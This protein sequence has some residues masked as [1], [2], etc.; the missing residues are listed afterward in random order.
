MIDLILF[1]AVIHTLD[2][3]MPRATAVAIWRERIV[4]VGTDSDIRALAGRN[5][6][7][8]NMDGLVILPGTIDSHV[9]FYGATDMLH[10]AN[11]YAS[12]SRR[13]A[14]ERVARFAAEHAAPDRDGWVVGYGWTQD[15]WADGGF[16]SAAD[17]DSMVM[18]R[19]VYLRSRSGH[20]AWVNSMALRLAGID[21][22]T[23]N[24]PGGEI[25][26]DATGEATGLLFEWPAMDL[27]GDRV[28]PLTPEALATRMKASQAW[29]HSQGVTGFH[30]LDNPDCLIGLQVLRERGELGLRVTKYVNREFLDAALTTGIR[31]GFGDDWLRIGGLK[32]FADGAIGT[33]TAAMFQPYE[34]EPDNLGLIVVSKEEMMELIPRASRAGLPST[35]H[36]IGDRAVRDVLDAFA[37]ARADE[38]ARGVPPEARRH[39]VEHVQLIDPADVN[40]LAELR[41]IASMQP[42]HATSDYPVADRYWG[43]RTAYSYNPR[44]Q[45][46]RGVVL[47]FGSDA[48]YDHLGAMRGIHAAVTRQRPDG[49]PPGGW[50]PEARITVDQAIRAY[51]IGAAYS[52]GME[53]RLGRIVPGYL[54]DL[55]MLDR[56]PYTE[57]PEQIH[58]IGV[59]GTMV[60]GVWRWQK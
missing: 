32:M 19:P 36:A 5:T 28:P 40:R 49:T 31:V 8:Q 26:R 25:V 7:E 52:V 55:T 37:F 56:D 47:A 17:L 54:A 57:P 51:T 38:A 18:D 39:R 44:L 6:I 50:H 35:I 33:R 45:A 11:L 27:V 20:A 59:R 29:L 3:A 46:D 14:A 48:P 53:D 16:P 43:A 9:H 15:D 58:A 12:A 23:P 13:E 21:K 42:I 30:D 24:P 41:L 34:G 60:G 4:A 10:S 22:T 1:N 2:D